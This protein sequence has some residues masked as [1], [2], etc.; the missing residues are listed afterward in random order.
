MDLYKAVLLGVLFSA[1]SAGVLDEYAKTEGARIMSIL[2]R[3]YSVGTVLECAIKCNAETAFTCRSFI[4]IEK[5]QECLTIPAN[6]KTEHVLR[7]TSTALY[8]KKVYLM[9]CVNGIGM[10]YR[11]TKSKTKSGKTCQ[12]WASKYPHNPNMTPSTHPNADLESNFCRNPDGDSK[13]PWCYTRDPETRWET[14]NVQDCSASKPPTVVELTCS[15]GDGVAY[16]GTVAV[17]TSGKACQAWAA[18]TPQKHNRTPDN[19]PSNGLDLN[20]C[21]NPDNER[22]PWCYT[23]DPETR[24]E[25]CKVPSCGDVPGPVSAGVLDEYAKTEGARIMSILKREYSVGTVLECAIKCNAETAFTCRSFIYIE[26]DQECLTIPANTKTE[27][28]LRR[29]ST[30]LYEKKVYL[31]ECVNG[32]GMDYRGTK[33][34][35][36]SGKTCQR[37]AS[38]YPHNPN[39]T[40]STHPNADLESNFCRN[41]DGDSKGPWCYTRD[42]ETR[43]ETCNVQDCSASKPPTVVELTCSTGDG[44]AYR[45]TVAV[46]TSGKACQAWAAQTPQKHNRTPDNYPSNGLDLN[47]CRNPDNER[48]PWCYTTDPETRWEYCK[49]P[50]CGDVPGPA[51]K[52]PT[53]VEE[54]TCST[55]DGVAYRGTVAVTTSGKACQAWAAQT[56]QKHNRTPD[57]YPS[58]GLDL[59]YCR[60]PDNERMPWCYTTDPETR[61]EYC[62]VPSCGD[63]PGPASKPPTVVELTCSTGD[64]VAYRGTVAVTTSGKACQAWAAQ[65]PQKHNRTP[66]NYPSNGLDLNYCRNPDNERMPWCYTTDPET[67]WEYC[68]VPSCGDVPGPASEPP[69]VVE[70][71]A[72][73]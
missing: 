67:R 5:D 47:Y 14:C 49:V 37:W 12:R 39:M 23:T 19:Y 30:A 17:T 70:A 64:G 52:P 8:E 59:N 55:G 72:K 29:T 62:K 36:K 28:V 18:Q 15:T 24:W 6:T 11:G 7:R 16:R 71:G 33:S 48:M 20:Y 27:H 2:K 4:Y 9:E 53:V 10:D 66:D 38:K 21:R 42:P 32:I 63:V 73:I 43:W 50:S 68:K 46:T 41:P 54:L 31:M 40:P 60:N 1:V 34:K 44:V 65:T 69:T 3:E 25:Y 51:S 61:W 35:T 13:G 57:N 22:M 45:G 56:P 26:K 58:N